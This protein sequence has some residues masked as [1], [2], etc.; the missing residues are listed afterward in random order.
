MENTKETNKKLRRAQV[1]ILAALLAALIL[2]A[3]TGFAFIDIIRGPVNADT[4]LALEE[5]AYVSVN[6]SADMGV[7]AERYTS[8]GRVTGRYIAVPMGEQLVAFL[9]PERYFESEEAIRAYTGDWISGRTEGLTGY[10]LTVGSVRRLTEREQA[11]MYDWFEL[12]N[13]W[14]T[15]AGAIGGVEDFTES[16]S[17]YVVCVDY[18]GGMS[19]IWVYI[20]SSLAWLLIIF[21]VVMGILWALGRFDERPGVEDVVTSYAPSSGR[22]IETAASGD[23]GTEAIT[24][25]EISG[26]G[27][28]PGEG[29]AAEYGAPA[30]EPEAEHD[31]EA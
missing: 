23:D 12:N 5:G 25:V 6:V 16:L 18:I 7:F 11:I 8:S 17:N 9:L 13:G 30:A 2:L 19:A 1:S 26:D 4:A 10:I 14:M 21:A 22:S 28:E 29:G 15:G 20:L 27:S 31:D 24:S 3:A